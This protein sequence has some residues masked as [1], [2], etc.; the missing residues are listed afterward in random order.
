MTEDRHDAQIRNLVAEL[1]ASAPPAPAFSRIADHVTRT[2]RGGR[3]MPASVHDETTDVTP[4]YVTEQPSRAKP[5]RFM[6]AFLAFTLATAGGVFAYGSLTGGDG[7]GTPEKAVEQLVDAIT[8]SDVAGMLESLA[9]NER[10]MLRTSLESLDRQARRLGLTKDLDLNDVS[11][12]QLEV[13]GL[14]LSATGLGNDVASVHV[15]GTLRS[16][17]TDRELPLGNVARELLVDALPDNGYQGVA[18]AVDDAVQDSDVQLITVR[19][20]D[21]WHVSV[22]YTVAE[23]LRK[24]AGD[25]AMPDF[26]RSPIAPLGASTPDGALQGLLDAQP[27]LEKVVAFTTPDESRV[28]YDYVPVFNLRG[29]DMGAYEYKV[30]DMATTVEGEGDRRIVHIDSFDVSYTSSY[31]SSSSSGTSED[32]SAPDPGTE[33]GTEEIVESTFRETFDGDC[34]TTTPSPLD[35]PSNPVSSTGNDKMC[36]A[37]ALARGVSPTAWDLATNLQVTVERHDGRWFVSPVQSLV[38]STVARL[39][40]V[41]DGEAVTALSAEDENTSAS[42]HLLLPMDVIGLAFGFPHSGLSYSLIPSDASTSGVI[43]EATPSSTTSV[44]EPVS[45]EPRTSV[46]VPATTAPEATPTTTT[47]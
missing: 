16:T 26:G 38:D 7:A 45:G 18:D 5:W 43:D 17:A 27:D 40:L 24:S 22:G 23:Y 10:V 31:S 2:A 20:G 33:P 37:D 1:A 12:V 6:A 42:T 39:A 41:P 11:G 25:V 19:D 36:R 21:G 34:F 15:T 8:D 35:D 9:P 30:N 14:E 32:G 3:S 4:L 44:V 13:S 47:R 28:L 46:P 29:S